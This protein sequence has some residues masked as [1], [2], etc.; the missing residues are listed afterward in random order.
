ME[1][2][3]TF[4]IALSSTLVAAY[5]QCP[6]KFWYEY[7]IDRVPIGV[8]VHLI[9]GAA[10][11][12][13][14]EVFRKEYYSGRKDKDAALVAGAR[15]LIK[16]YGDFD[17][18]NSPKTWDRVLTTF[19]AYYDEHPPETDFIEPL[20]LNGE[21]SV[22]FSFA[23]PL[24]IAHPDTGD[25]ILYGGKFDSIMQMAALQVGFDD[26]TTGSMGQTWSDQWGLRGQFT[27]YMWGAREHG[28]KLGAFIVRG[29]AIQKT[30]VKFATAITYRP[31]WMIDRWYES[32]LSTVNRM[33]EDYKSNKWDLNLADACTTYGGCA[34][35]RLCESPDPISWLDQYYT[36][37]TWEPIIAEGL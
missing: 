17:P 2:K 22:E 9:A 1:L 15:A 20:I 32:L 24:P 35:T 37:R 3:P 23:V 28:I 29:A 8:S 31:D 14:Q 26:K 11:A 30:Q 16:E 18:D 21:P 25:P 7:I 19:I 6:T 27:G 33:I 34:F 4:P 13:G 5:K 10:Y 36:K 12:K